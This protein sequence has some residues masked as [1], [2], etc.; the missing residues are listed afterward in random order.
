MEKDLLIAN[1]FANLT[2]LY[3]SKIVFT[4]EQM[5]KYQTAITNL[6]N[7]NKELE[8][9]CQDKEI[10]ETGYNNLR[11]C[12]NKV[13]EKVLGPNY[14]N[15]ACDTYT[16]DKLTC[17][18]IINKKVK[19]LLK[20][21]DSI[22]ESAI[23]AKIKELHEKMQNYKELASRTTDRVEKRLICD[24]IEELKTSIKYLQELLIK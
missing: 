13:T 18:D 15:Y 8:S 7:K 17:E 11:E 23:K 1:E 21:Q 2:F 10:Y 6:I 19:I 24:Q 4:S 20:P 5:K 3:G 16:C 9:K 14:Y 22:P 12:W